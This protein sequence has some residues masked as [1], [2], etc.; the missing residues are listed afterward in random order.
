MKN[1]LKMEGAQKLSKTEQQAISGG[2]S[3]DWNCDNSGNVCNPALNGADCGPVY[4]GSLDCPSS[5]RCLCPI[6]ATEGT[7]YANMA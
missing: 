4:P 5:Y 7:C 1:L 3:T 6:G 2:K